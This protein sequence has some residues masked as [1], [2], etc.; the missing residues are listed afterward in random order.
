M[1]ELERYRAS[2]SVLMWQGIVRGLNSVP[3]VL[4]ELVLSERRLAAEKPLHISCYSQHG[5]VIID[6]SQCTPKSSRK[7]DAS[8]VWTQMAPKG[9]KGVL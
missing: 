8:S 9:H 7:T 2:I 1:L 5:K 3:F 6:T 4:K